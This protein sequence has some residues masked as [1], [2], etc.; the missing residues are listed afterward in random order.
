MLK[1]NHCYPWQNTIWQH[2]AGLI[3]ANKFPHAVLFSGKVGIGKHDLALMLAKLLL[4][5]Q[6]NVDKFSACG[7]CRDCNFFTADSHPD[8]YQ[9]HPENAAS[10]IKIDQTR[11]LIDKLSLHA[12]QGGCKIIII[13][14][15]HS[16]TRAAADAILKTLED[17]LG[18]AIFI[19]V[20]DQL[21]NL[22][23]TIKSRCQITKMQLLD[24]TIAL[25]WLQKTSE[26]S[27]TRAQQLMLFAGGA[28][29]QVKTWVE[30]DF[31][32]DKKLINNWLYTNESALNISSQLENMDLTTVIN[33]TL[34]ILHA[35]SKCLCNDHKM[36]K[37]LGIDLP[38]VK[39]F[40]NYSLANLMQ[41]ISHVL[42]I[43]SLWMTQV[44]LNKKY[45]LDRLFLG[46]NK[47]C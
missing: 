21:H 42:Q 19:L 28:P 24:E 25:D 18:K 36:I 29:L 5:Q 8:V 16:F 1:F 46:I 22:S 14:H 2:Y 9:I 23:T 47:Y 34:I 3:F 13:N 41:C 4:C 15:A 43:K 17:P 44:T 39:R 10:N 26:I 31:I 33:F 40:S 12:H 11:M 37:D 20:T 30:Q 7:K 38:A 45:F 6:P 32:L 35:M 27:I